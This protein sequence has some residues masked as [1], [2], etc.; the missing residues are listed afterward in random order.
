MSTQG[1]KMP[2]IRYPFWT[3]QVG[4][5]EH[6][7]I[8]RTLNSNYLNEGDLTERFE[9]QVA[10]M[11]GCRF[12]VAVTSGTAALYLSLKALG[13]GA[14]DEVIVPDVT[15]IATANAVTMTGATPVPVDVNPMTLNIAPDAVRASIT[16][17]TAAVIPVHVSGRAADLQSIQKI[18]EQHALH[19]IEDA[20]EAMMSRSRGRC[21]GTIAKLGCFS[22]S[23]NKTIST[24]Q[25]G[26]VATDD[27]K[28][29]ERL[30]ELKDQ[31]RSVRGTGG[32]DAHPV[33]GFNFKFTNL[34]A[35]VGIGQL[36]MLPQRI[37]RLRAIQ[38]RYASNLRGVDGILL[39]GF[40]EG[41]VPQWV[42]ARVDRRDELIEFLAARGAQC[43]PFWHPLHTHPPYR[44]DDADFADS[45]RVGPQSVW[46]PSSFT[47]SD[48][49]VDE[50][51]SFIR[52]FL[53]GARAKAA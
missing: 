27:R 53:S 25:G 39:Y 48:Q 38:R 17:R 10:Q 32:A 19:V 36:E 18:A 42:D 51:C 41:E 8:A 40:R 23:P 14:G 43:R 26:L 30:R 22:L 47:L 1:K 11:L 45:C 28:L 50:V 52:T 37:D 31:G 24:G 35:A 7:L 44:K 49:D 5:A 20:A 15:F 46:L 2:M 16:P 9:S 12:V 3:P 4:T 33:V 29:H 34:Q 21:L 13:I 6:G